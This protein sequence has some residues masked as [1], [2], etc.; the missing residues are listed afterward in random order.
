M[1][2]IDERESER[3]MMMPLTPPMPRNPDPEV[4]KRQEQIRRE[5]KLGEGLSEWERDE[6]ATLSDQE[7]S[8]LKTTTPLRVFS[9]VVSIIFILFLFVLILGANVFHHW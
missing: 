1:R 6:H 3:R 8:Q 2:N 7:L 4:L 5:Q 9:L